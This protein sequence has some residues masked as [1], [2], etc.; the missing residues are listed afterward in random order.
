VEAED[1]N[2]MLEVKVPA[3]SATRRMIGVKAA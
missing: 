1:A 2:G 3:P